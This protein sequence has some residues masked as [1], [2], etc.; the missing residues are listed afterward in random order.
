MR[1]LKLSIDILT[2]QSFDTA[3]LARGYGTV[4]GRVL[5]GDFGDTAEGTSPRCEDTPLASCDGKCVGEP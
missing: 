3:P 1:K 4:Q 2:V 5:I